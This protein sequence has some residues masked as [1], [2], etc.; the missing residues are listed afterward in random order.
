MKS[1]LQLLGIRCTPEEGGK[2]LF[3]LIVRSP[4]FYQ[5]QKPRELPRTSAASGR[6]HDTSPPA[7]VSFLKHDAS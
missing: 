2:S 1:L 4:R 5:L 6:V 3:D 7:S